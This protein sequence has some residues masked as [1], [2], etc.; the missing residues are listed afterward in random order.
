[1]EISHIYSLCDILCVNETEAKLMTNLRVDTL[2][3]CRIACKMI[4][5]KGC[6]SVILTLGG[7]GAFY[8]NRNQTLHIPVPQNI[9]I[10]DTTVSC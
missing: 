3:D 1:M 8:V 6:G 7:N 9:E 2:D 4:L 10:V 5:D